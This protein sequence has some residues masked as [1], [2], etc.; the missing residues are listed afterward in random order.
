MRKKSKEKRTVPTFM[1]EERE[2][3]RGLKR[4]FGILENVQFHYLDGSYM[5]VRLHFMHLHMCIIF[6]NN[7]KKMEPD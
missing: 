5:D 4:T 1:T 2:L 6:H 7:I 3:G